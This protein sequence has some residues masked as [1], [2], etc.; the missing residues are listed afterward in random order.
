M[1]RPSTGVGLALALVAG[2]ATGGAML[3]VAKSRP[4]ERL[5]ETEARMRA[6]RGLSRASASLA[7]A[8]LA[9]SATEHYRGAFANKAMYVPLAASSAVLAAGLHGSG[10]A[11]A[12]PRKAREAVW[13]L[14]MLTGVGGTGFHL[15]NIAKR[16]GAVS[17]QNLFYAAP[18]GAPAGLS[19]AG[20]FGW[21]GERLREGRRGARLAAIAVSRLTALL[22][23]AG[24]VGAAGEAGLLHYRG[25]YQDPFMFV[26]VTAP[27]AAAGLLAAAA[28]RPT[29]ARVSLAR[30]ALAITAIVG[31]A[32]AA[33]HTIG[34]GRMMGGWR[35]W[36][37]NFLA[38]PPIPAPP[39]FTS[40]A[41]AGL[42][43]LEL[44]EA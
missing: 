33:F 14:A 30:A 20:V 15:Y 31:V 9:D 37:Q 22:T 42:A 19:L 7:A 38:G 4:S 5:D 35:N 39:S 6:A 23:A 16:P 3:A 17:W 44:I 1:E 2:A 13:A 41:L 24:L 40:L 25:A 36:S 26:P 8:V 21:L 34:V 28:A 29:P 18:I 43:A 12:R 10:D 27:P 11:E 32:G